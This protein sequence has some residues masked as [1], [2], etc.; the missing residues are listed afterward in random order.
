MG[1]MFNTPRTVST[2]RGLESAER[3]LENYA[4]DCSK[5]EQ[6][7]VLK[8]KMKNCTLGELQGYRRAIEELERR[9]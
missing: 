3:D 5:E 2:W 1:N 8:E 4:R 6:I 9:K 7:R